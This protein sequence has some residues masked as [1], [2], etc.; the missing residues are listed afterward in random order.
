[1][2]AVDRNPEV[3]AGVVGAGDV[4]G[5]SSSARVVLHHHR[6][7]RGRIGVVHHLRLTPA[8]VVKLLQ[9]RH[10]VELAVEAIPGREGCADDGSGAGRIVAEALP[11]GADHLAGVGL[12]V[13]R[14]V[15]RAEPWVEWPA[16]VVV[17]RRRRVVGVVHDRAGLAVARLLD[18]LGSGG[19][20]GGRARCRQ[21]DLS[22]E[23]RRVEES[24]AAGERGRTEGEPE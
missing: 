23:L 15:E 13:A 2:T 17:L 5:R 18:G 7:G 20:S 22:F 10:P 3:P 21:G 1:V 9:R 19:L 8:D 24:V 12:R 14:L 6:P 4:G 16:E 11:G